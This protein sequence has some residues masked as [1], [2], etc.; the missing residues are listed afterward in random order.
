M[1]AVEV[2]EQPETIPAQ[3]QE[4]TAATVVT[5][6][7]AAEAAEPAQT[8]PTVEPAETA[9]EALL[10]LLNTTDHALDHHTRFT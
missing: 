8:A 2:A 6:A 3:R 1:A 4:A 10:L 7:P 5:T 9:P